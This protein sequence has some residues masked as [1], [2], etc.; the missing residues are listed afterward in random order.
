MNT[1]EN[2]AGFTLTENFIDEAQEA[3]LLRHITAEMIGKPA[4]N[5]GLRSRICRWGFDYKD[6]D[7]WLALAPAWLYPKPELGEFESVTVNQYLPGCRIAPHVDSLNFGSPIL[8]LSL[9]NDA[10]FCLHPPEHPIVK[11]TLPRRSLASMSGEV[12]FVWEHSIEKVKDATRYSIVYR[13][14]I[15][16]K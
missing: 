11:I 1:C 16:R 4:N 5:N 10:Q 6:K 13:K 9:G 15:I 7:I 8:I 12:R 3:E 2:M 14:R